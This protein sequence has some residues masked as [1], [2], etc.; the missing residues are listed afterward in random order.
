MHER[1]LV[2]G[3]LMI[4]QDGIGASRSVPNLEYEK[5]GKEE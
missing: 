4:T 3:W 1:L 2:L 5:M